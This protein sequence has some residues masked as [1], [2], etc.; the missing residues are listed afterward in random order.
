[1]T[2]NL[3]PTEISITIPIK[4]AVQRHIESLQATLTKRNEQIE[5]LVKR[6]E[7]AEAGEPNV[8]ALARARKQGWQDACSKL[9][10]LTQDTAGA[11]GKLRAGAWDVYL[12]AERAEA[13]RYRAE[14]AAS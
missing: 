10:G 8:E 13:E 6:V 7:E 14:R 2:L 11:L 4:E 9:M 5:R 12:E 3:D 1:M